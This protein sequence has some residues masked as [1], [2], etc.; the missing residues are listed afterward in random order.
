MKSSTHFYGHVGRELTTPSG[1]ICRNDSDV[2]EGASS[3]GYIAA[4]L[5][6]ETFFVKKVELISSLNN[7]TFEIAETAELIKMQMWHF[8]HAGSRQS[9]HVRTVGKLGPS[10]RPLKPLLLFSRGVLLQDVSDEMLKSVLVHDRI[11][12]R[13]GRSPPPPSLHDPSEPTS[14]ESFRKLQGRPLD[15]RN[16]KKSKCEY[17]ANLDFAST[18]ASMVK[19][20]SSRC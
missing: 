7:V 12:R 2:K 8:L 20:K 13:G 1:E 9:Q 3:G 16:T 6:N 15:G 18:D 4:K 17:I 10:G 5:E 14:S 11:V 19:A